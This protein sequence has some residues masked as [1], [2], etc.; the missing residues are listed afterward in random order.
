VRDRG[1]DVLAVAVDLQRHERDHVGDA[2]SADVG[3]HRE[4]LRE[5]VEDRLLDELLREREEHLG[6]HG[7]DPSARRARS[8]APPALA[9]NPAAAAAAAHAHGDVGRDG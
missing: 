6:Q 8:A 2:R 7:R 9:A 1:F 5:V 4:P 3:L